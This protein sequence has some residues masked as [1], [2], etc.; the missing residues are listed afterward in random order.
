M[1]LLYRAQMICSNISL[2][3]VEVNNLRKMFTSNSY[4]VN[5]FNSV[6]GKFL[7]KPYTSSISDDGEEAETPCVLLKV[8]FLWKCSIDLNALHR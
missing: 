4:P 8:P 6:L 2:F 5:L 3:N 1:C 7:N